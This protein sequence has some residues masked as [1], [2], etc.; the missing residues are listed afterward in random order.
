MI[1][2]CSLFLLQIT[3]AEQSVTDYSL[4]FKFEINTSTQSVPIP[5]HPLNFKNRKSMVKSI[6][7]LLLSILW[8]YPSSKTCS[9][10]VFVTGM[11][12]LATQTARVITPKA[13]G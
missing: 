4:I 6:L 9:D 12:A 3:G 5:P 13:L 2:L 10:D 1:L 8:V 7:S 11:I